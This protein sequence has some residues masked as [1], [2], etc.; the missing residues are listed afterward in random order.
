MPTNTVWSPIKP[1]TSS[2]TEPS[3]TPSMGTFSSSIDAKQSF[4]P[5]ALLSSRIRTGKS[6]NKVPV[7]SPVKP[8]TP[9]IA[10]PSPKPSLTRSS[11]SIL[12]DAKQSFHGVESTPPD[13]FLFPPSVIHTGKSS[14]KVPVS[15]IVRIRLERPFVILTHLLLRRHRYILPRTRGLN[16]PLLHLWLYQLR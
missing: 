3:P 1:V 11:F 4:V 15:N 5:H 8:L 16:R 10:E 2:I 14:N 6:S 13:A 12:N 7:W 9:S